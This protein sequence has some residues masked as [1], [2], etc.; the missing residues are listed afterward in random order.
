MT[1]LRFFWLG[2]PRIEGGVGAL[3]LPTRKTT[4]LLAFLSGSGQ[5]LSRESLAAILWPEFNQ[6]RAH[7]NLRRAL[8]S[9]HQTLGAGIVKSDRE[10]VGLDPTA[11]VWI[12]VGE[13]CSH[14]S[15]VQAHAHP[16]I[17]CPDCV[18]QLEQGVSLYRGDFLAGFNL[19]DCP[20][21]DDWQ[22]M[23]REGFR[24]NLAWML[25][26]LTGAYS[27]NGEWEKAILRSR[28][29]VS[30]DRLHEPAQR[31][32]MQ[33]YALSGQ[34]SAAIRQYEECEHWLQAD[35]GQSP[36]EVTIALYQQIRTG[37]I[38]K[39][40]ELSEATTIHPLV[41]PAKPPL[42]KTKLFAPHRR[43]DLV[44]RQHLLLK[45][46]QGAQRALTLISAP[47]GYGKT[48][49]LSEWIGTLQKAD[50]SSP[51]AICWL[52]LDPGDND[53]IRFLTYLTAALE[54]V[55]PGV[56]AETRS[57]IL[58]SPSLHPTT[59][60]SML[61]NELQELPQSVL[62]VLD[63]YQC[64]SNPAIHDGIT[65]LIDHLPANVHVVIATRSD[66]PFPLARL[67]G[68]NQLTEIRANDLC[69]TTN[70]TAEFLNQACNLA[71]TPE[72]IMILE[73]RTEGWIAGLQMAA[74]SMQGRLD[75]AEF[76]EAFSGSHRFIMDYLAEEA[77]NRQSIETQEFLL[78][79]SILEQLSESL[80]DSV[81]VSKHDRKDD[82]YQST[83]DFSKLQVENQSRLLQLE[84]SNLFIVPLDDD[85]VWYRY[86]H[87]FADLLRTH[88]QQAS[89][90]LIPILHIRASAWFEKEGWT[91]ESIH[92]SIAAKNWGN[93]SRL[94]V[95]HIPAYLE[96]GQMTTIMKWVED[97]PHD[98]IYQNPKL[99]TL[100]AEVITQAGMIDQIDPFLNK[101][102]EIV[103]P[104]E[105]HG[106]NS[107]VGQVLGLSLKDI[108]AIRSMVG[109][110]RGLKSVC[111]GDPNRALNFTQRALNDNPEMEPKELAV[112]FW[113]EGWAYR[114]LGCL[115]LA[116]ESLTKATEYALES[117][118][119]LRDPWT[120]LANATRLVGKLHQAGDIISNSL[121]LAADRG[122]HNQG[123]LSRDE[124]FLSFIFLEQNQL[125]LAF[126]HANRAIAHTQ[127]WPSHHI[128]ATA[129]TSLAQ[130][131]LARDD[132]DGCLCAIQKADQERKNRLMNPFVHSLVDVTLAQIWISRGEWILLDQ[133]SSNQ[134]STL[135][136]KLATG[137]SIDEFLEMRLIMLIR[138][139]M[140][141][142]KI[143]HNLERNE[144]CLRLL[145]Q[146]ENSSRSVGRVNS[147]VEILILK[148]S[149]RFS[150]EKTSEAI[151]GLDNCLS[152]AEAGGY[153]RIFLNTGEPARALL[154]AYLQKSNPTY[155]SYALKILREF[156]S[157][158]MTQNPLEEFLEPL[159][160]R[161]IEVLRLLTEGYS[162]RQMA[163]KLVLAEGTVKFHVHNLLEKLQVDS[164]TQA[165][166]RAK[167]LDLL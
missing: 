26:R 165:I 71:L 162:N 140:E 88:L 18:V 50:S 89:P 157:L 139:W 80:C 78:Q 132:L 96:N 11:P 38:G 5:P 116:I 93:A 8:V 121:Q 163:E 41:F 56:S 111:S 95:Q 84:R 21:F 122:I 110:L 114:S 160:S 85:R 145:V 29:W 123:N 167:A 115:D 65:F 138:V 33:V 72:Q 124:S 40:S 102:E 90:N 99:C 23:Q 113:V 19:K 25:E 51:W 158:R 136:G 74:L 118:A 6:T 104:R 52:S 126:T 119:I 100:V 35:L 49:L 12:D 36:E 87:L 3:H 159:T 79:T 133:W 152:M 24:S 1:I 153:M 141:K 94:V 149:I 70:E 61:I 15:G 46:G 129:Y 98:I 86:H 4:A 135:N 20:E 9:T 59:P 117:R 39:Q 131:L 146:L 17:V 150:Q 2:S 13:F 54:N 32:L 106:A 30:L 120:D 48:T 42:I 68:R 34:R 107:T 164:R 7:A 92:H 112:L 166:A 45:L 66:P 148:E 76:I 62:L 28:Q 53:M 108:T 130:I 63:D 101:A 60:L 57:I 22:H 147:L 154:S 143:D 44:S 91:E 37:K 144:D 10:T 58:S 14:L 142:T 77:L 27:A 161:E 16:E 125:D 97:L 69:F 151:C 109:I 105:I 128:I 155:K 64:I 103:S 73:N 82:D 55:H 137:D 47:A 31:R 156:G 134:I 67:R 75:I 83:I 81:I 127:W 43:A